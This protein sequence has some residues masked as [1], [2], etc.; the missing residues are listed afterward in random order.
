M[1]QSVETA[2]TSPKKG[3]GGFEGY[4]SR[5]AGRWAL[6]GHR[7]DDLI[8]IKDFLTVSD[9]SVKNGA[10]PLFAKDAATLILR[11]LPPALVAPGNL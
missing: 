2:Q 3:G 8:E 11:V 6:I 7:L 10:N 4:G 1:F 5:D 9:E